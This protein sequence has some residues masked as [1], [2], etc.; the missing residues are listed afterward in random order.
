[1]ATVTG[2][3]IQTRA[4]GGPART[5]HWVTVVALAAQFVVGY[6]LDDDDSGQG[7]GRG[8]GR[9]EGSGHG[10]GRGRGGDDVDAGDLLDGG[11]TLLTVHVSLGLLI[12]LLAVLRLVTR[13]V[14]GLP[15]WAETLTLR[16]RRL[17]SITE[18][19]LLAML[20]AIPLTGLALVLGDD[21]LLP[22]HVTAHVV[23]FVALAAHVGLVLKHQLVNRDRLLSR[24][25]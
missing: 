13:R 7:R 15:A 21:D 22:L 18:R 8:R 6:L 4:Y 11:W 14:A 17:A 12:L 1:M 20:F 9:G 16:E 10:R 5:L 3:V 24:M 25:W 23:F 2:T 19:V